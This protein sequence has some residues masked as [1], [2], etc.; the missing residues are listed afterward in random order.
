MNIL[1]EPRGRPVIAHRGGA[2]RAPENTLEAMRLGIADGADA[3]EMDVRMSADGEVVV[4]H[5]PTVERTTGAAGAVEKMTLSELR[6]LDAGS[7]FRGR[8]PSS[9]SSERHQIPTFEE[10]L[11]T[12]PGVPFL[13]EIKAP[14][15]AAETRRLIETYGAEDR[16]LVDGYSTAAL[17]VFRGSRIACGPGRNGLI[18]LLVKSVTGIRDSVPS[19]VSALSIPRTYHG[20]PLPMGLLTSTMRAAGKPIH[21]WT[22]NDPDEARMLWDRGAAGIITDNVPAILA[23]RSHWTAHHERGHNGATP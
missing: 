21:I 22:V 3:L 12:F 14:L 7:H 19:D 1:L 9:G 11:R 16:C 2:A 20:V 6:A 5:D 18:A 17:R 15:A 8:P 13:I 23:A 4:I 10:V